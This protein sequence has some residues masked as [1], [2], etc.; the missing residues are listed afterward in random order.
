MRL[1][2]SRTAACAGALCTIAV[3]CARGRD[4]NGAVE[5]SGSIGEVLVEVHLLDLDGAPVEGAQVGTEA[6]ATVSTDAVGEGVVAVDSHSEVLLS[7]VQRD[8][9][10]LV[11]TLAAEDADLEVEIPV[12]SEAESRML[13]ALVGVQWDEDKG[14]VLFNVGG[15]EGVVVS[16]PGTGPFYIDEGGL[17]VTG[18]TSTSEMG[19]GF[20]VNAPVG[21]QELTFSEAC[22]T[23]ALSWSP[24]ADG[25]FP[26]PSMAAAVSFISVGC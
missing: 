4:S 9:P 2:G 20:F 7:V 19:T 21:T 25:A 15:V 5:D 8:G 6:G 1:F 23:T 3:G 13:T 16:G 17:P 12:P 22:M 10:A 18:A 14:L 11:T 24:D 26:V